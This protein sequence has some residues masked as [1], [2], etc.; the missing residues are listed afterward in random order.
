VIVLRFK[1]IE[2]REKQNLNQTNLA[3][4]AGISNGTLCDIESYRK[5]PNIKT[6]E[7]IAKAL[8]VKVRDLLDED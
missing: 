8:E 7:K 4:K 6:L 2:I 3:K 5:S 1:I